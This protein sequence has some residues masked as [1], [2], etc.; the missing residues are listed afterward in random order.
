MRLFLSN[1]ATS[2]DKY[3]GLY[4][5][6]K[7]QRNKKPYWVHKAEFYSV[8]WD[9]TNWVVGRY[10]DNGT[11]TIQGPKGKENWPINIRQGWTYLSKK[12]IIDAGTYDITFE[13]WS[14]IKGAI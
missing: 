1:N 10:E 7:E 13:D 11:R 8:W 6:S 9:K 14:K 3:K 4:V 2:H 5:L 12:Q